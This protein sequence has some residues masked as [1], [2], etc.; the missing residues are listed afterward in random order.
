MDSHFLSHFSYL[1][2]KLLFML[3][4]QLRYRFFLCVHKMDSKL[5]AWLVSLS[6]RVWWFMRTDIA[7]HHLTTHSLTHSLSIRS[8]S[9]IWNENQI[10]ICIKVF[11]CCHFPYGDIFQKLHQINWNCP[12]KKNQ[13]N[14]FSLSLCLASSALNDF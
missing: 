4:V 10:E 7:C 1:L 5:L 9:H 13:I 8:Y 12:Q 11:F 14:V 6:N 2:E 3:N